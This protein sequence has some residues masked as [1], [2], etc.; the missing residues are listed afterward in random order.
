MEIAWQAL[1]YSRYYDESELWAYPKEIVSDSEIKLLLSEVMVIVGIFVMNNNV[2]KFGE[3]ICVQESKGGTG[4]RLTGTLAETVIISQ[5]C[6][7][8]KRMENAGVKNE[9]IPKV[10]DNV[11]LCFTVIRP[12]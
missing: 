10:V 3:D 6:V 5:C 7:F 4:N 8:S 11:T 12:G 1:L 2:F 9:T